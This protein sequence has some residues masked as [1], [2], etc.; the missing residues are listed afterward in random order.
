MAA[1]RQLISLIL[2]SVNFLDL[3]RA[4]T[5]ML[6]PPSRASLWRY[7]YNTPR[8]NW[9]DMTDCGGYERHHIKNGGNCGVC[10]DASDEPTPRRHEAGGELSPN[11]T[12]VKAFET[13]SYLTVVMETSSSLFGHFEFR[14]CNISHNME[15]PSQNCFDQ[16]Q[17]TILESEL[18]TEYQIG[19][20]QGIHVLNL[21]LPTGVVCSHCI[22]QWT[23]KTGFTTNQESCLTCPGGESKCRACKGCGNQ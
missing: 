15:T 16:T 12:P 20:R 8:N 17:L 2:L 1:L 13:G 5:R 10:G 9:D 21:R 23:H 11:P 7:G 19:S 4:G 22:V 18:G 3:S 6:E 14:L